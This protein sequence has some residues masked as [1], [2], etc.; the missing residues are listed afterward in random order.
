MPKKYYIE[1]GG[2]DTAFDGHWGYEDIALVF[3]L[4]STCAMTVRY[5]PDAKVY[6]QEFP[7]DAAKIQQ[8]AVRIN[9]STNPNYL[10]VCEMIPGFDDFKKRQ[11]GTL[12]L[13]KNSFDGE[14]KSQKL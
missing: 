3:R 2:S 7:E 5:L 1:S 9:K 4:V 10:R 14:L 13:S 6:H 12:R 11:F 8:N